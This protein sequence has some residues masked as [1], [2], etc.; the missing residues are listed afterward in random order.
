MIISHKYRFVFIELAHTGSTAVAHE[1]Q[2]VYEAEKLRGK[3]R[4][5]HLF[6]RTASDDERTYYTFSA[7]RNPL[8]V[9]VSKYIKYKSDHRNE[10][11]D[12]VTIARKRG[13]GHHMDR[14]L[15]RM[16]VEEDLDFS[17]FFLRVYRFPFNT[18]ACLDHA[19][20]DYVMRYENLEEDFAKVLAAIGIEQT[21]PLPVVNSSP[22][23]RDDFLSYYSPEAIERAK[24]VFIGYMRE[25]GYEFPREWGQPAYTSVDRAKYR[26]TTAFL[27]LYWRH[28][29][30]YL[31]RKNW[32]APPAKPAPGEGSSPQ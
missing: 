2:D 26:V 8:D 5:Y 10:F 18:W 6:Y 27:T 11:T 14:R 19:N 7:V 29:K 16:I 1:L 20:F 32:D 12:P 17:E 13:L 31:W 24:K 21:R 15:Q 30:Q 3:H 9:A 22:G 4:P 25:W 23:K 28:L